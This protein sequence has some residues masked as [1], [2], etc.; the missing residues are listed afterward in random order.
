ML[1]SADKNAMIRVFNNLI[2]NATQ[3]F[4]EGKIGKI[5]IIISQEIENFEIEIK[6]NG[7][8]IEL[9]NIQ[10]LFKPYFTTKSSG[11]G[12]GLAMVKQIIENHRGNIYCESTPDVGTSFIINLPKVKSKGII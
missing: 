3:S 9:E 7:S 2:K 12:L 8:G 5:E 1:I 11:T 4:E 10:N 6:D